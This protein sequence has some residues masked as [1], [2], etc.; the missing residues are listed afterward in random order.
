VAEVEA[1]PRQRWGRDRLLFVALLVSLVVWNLP[2]GGVIAWPFKLLAT[3]IHELSHGIV[4]LVTAAGFDQMQIYRDTSGLAYAQEGVNDAGRAAI[5]AAAGYMGTP[6]WGALI[7]WTGQ[8]ARRA[9]RAM[10][11]LGMA[12]A[13]SAWLFLANDFGIAA[14]AIGA[15]ACLVLAIFAGEGL[16]TFAA[17]FIGA[18]LCINALLD[19]RVLFRSNLVVN[20]QIMG[21]SDA[22]SMTLATFG[23]VSKTGVWMWSALWLVWSLALFFV[24]LRVTRERDRGQGSLVVRGPDTGDHCGEAGAGVARQDVGQ[25]QRAEPAL[26]DGTVGAADVAPEDH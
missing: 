17:L 8:S 7:L 21:L 14:T 24:V 18:Q 2:Y 15:A 19:I 13:L 23:E 4:M 12:M 1:R 10:F 25:E 26:G 22:E 16:I 3:W 6:L 9:R 20:G 5:A 11:V